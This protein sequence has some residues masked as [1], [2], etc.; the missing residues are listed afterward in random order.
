MH[1][2]NA[3]ESI[4]MIIGVLTFFY[5]IHQYRL[6]NSLERFE[7]FQSMAA[8][9]ENNEEIVRVRDEL[10]QTASRPF[11]TLIDMLSWLSSSS[12]R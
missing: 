8:M 7:K 9:Y 10:G 2:K 3:V 5:A 11:R 4:T 12:L 1:V 6:K